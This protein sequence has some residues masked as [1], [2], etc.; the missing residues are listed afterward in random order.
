MI[1]IG[2]L[3]DPG[4]TIYKGPDDL[5]A[6]FFACDPRATRGSGPLCCGCGRATTLGIGHFPGQ[7]RLFSL[8][9]LRERAAPTL[10]KSTTYARRFIVNHGHQS[11][12]LAHVITLVGG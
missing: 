9:G 10:A 11:V 7:S 5:R 1:L 4:S 12:D 2:S 6:L 3:G 8:F